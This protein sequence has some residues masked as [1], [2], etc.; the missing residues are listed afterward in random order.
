MFILLTGATGI[1]FG[2]LLHNT[3][4]AIVTYFALG[5]VFNLFTIPALEK[6]GR[7]V[8]T[9]ETYGWV[10]NGQWSGHGAQIAASA[11]LWILLPLTLGLVRTLR[12][13]V[14]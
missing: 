14:R 7:W 3:A 2:A 13:E 8:N 12:R 6:A 10:L 1:A 5:A 9:G 11:A 4:A